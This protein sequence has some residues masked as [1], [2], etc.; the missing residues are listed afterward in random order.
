[1][2]Y[3]F[4]IPL[5]IGDINGLE[6]LDNIK[7]TVKQGLKSLVLTN[8]G[9]L[10][11]YLEY[12]VGIEGLLFENANTDEYKSR[13]YTQT[14]KYLPAIT[15]IQCEIRKVNNSAYV[16]IVYAINSVKITDTLEMDV[17]RNV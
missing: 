3:T 1:M 7:S 15:V 13:I 8:P 11:F 17:T 9:E 10:M 2:I 6:T 4:K 16:K 14:K 5:T 12:G